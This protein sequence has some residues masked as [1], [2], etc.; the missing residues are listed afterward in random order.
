MESSPSSSPDLRPGK[1][2][3]A[4]LSIAGRT[5]VVKTMDSTIKLFSAIGAF[6]LQLDKVITAAGLSL[7]A[8]ERIAANRVPTTADEWDC[9]FPEFARKTS[10]EMTELVQWMRDRATS[11]EE[12]KKVLSS[13]AHIRFGPNLRTR[14]F[15]AAYRTVFQKKRGRPRKK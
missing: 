2:A 8:G 13:E 12:R 6:K 14:V 4:V 7:L 5:R 1:N 9:L 15:D 10:R 3:D 11:G